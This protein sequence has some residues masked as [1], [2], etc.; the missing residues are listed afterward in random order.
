MGARWLH[1]HQSDRASDRPLK[2]VRQQWEHCPK[3]TSYRTILLGSSQQKWD[4]DR[5]VVK[6]GTGTF[7]SFT[8]RPGLKGHRWM[9]NIIPFLANPSDQLDSNNENTWELAP[10]YFSAISHDI[11][12]YPNG[13]MSPWYP[14]DLMNIAASHSTR[15]SCLHGRRVPHHPGPGR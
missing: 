13:I 8:S 6:A 1:S 7:H 4:A 15:W 10:P 2:H 12:S 5:P 3:R 11:P 14:H 9:F